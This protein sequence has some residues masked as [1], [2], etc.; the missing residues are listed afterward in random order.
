MVV[1]RM[2]MDVLMDIVK[3]SGL[4]SV[5]V[6]SFASAAAGPAGGAAAQPTDVTHGGLKVFGNGGS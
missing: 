5:A 4:A 2:R 3:K 1:G 6:R